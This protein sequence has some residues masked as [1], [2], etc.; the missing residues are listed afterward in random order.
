MPE[1]LAALIGPVSGP[2]IVLVVG[3]MLV[4]G[5]MRGF[6][7][8]GASMIIV[9]VFSQ[10]LGP[11]VAVP[12]AALSGLPAMI[13]LMPTAVRESERGFVLPFGIASCIA[14]P[15]GTWALVIVDGDV[16][17]IVI[18]LV[19]IAMT[20]MLYRGWQPS[21]RSG[22]GTLLG[23]GAVAGL[24][25][26]SAGIGGPPAVAMALARSGKAQQQRANVIGAVAALS[27]CSLVPLWYYGL[28]TTQVLVISLILIPL[29]SGA[30]WFGARFFQTR[31]HR[32]FRNAGLLLLAA[33]GI[34]T[35]MNAA[36]DYLAG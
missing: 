19:V 7:G 1:V 36:R 27:L 30:T 15:F 29:Y 21:Q 3:T 16:M 12:T 2:A 34:V 8:F 26:G 32:H 17:K 4:A 18:A 20:I 33:V 11:T 22:S 31:G 24:I 23:I 25:Q 13:Q 9:L 6:V 28:F 35:L 10:V 14:A 5:F